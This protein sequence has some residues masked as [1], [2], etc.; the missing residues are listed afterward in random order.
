MNFA[1]RFSIAFY[2]SKQ[3]ISWSLRRKTSAET[4]V[5]LPYW[6]QQN[7]KK[8]KNNSS[9]FT[10]R[11]SLRTAPTE[12]LCD[13]GAIQC[14]QV[15]GFLCSTMFICEKNEEECQKNWYER[16]TWWNFIFRSSFWVP[17]MATVLLINFF[18]ISCESNFYHLFS[19]IV[20]FQ[21]Q[22]DLEQQT[23]Q[24]PLSQVKNRIWTLSSCTY[25][26]R[27]ICRENY[28]NCTTKATDIEKSDSTEGTSCLKW[29][30][31]NGGRKLFA[32]YQKDADKLNKV[33]YRYRNSINPKDSERE[34]NWHNT[35]NYFRN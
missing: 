31:Y 2:F 19:I 1:N 26:V 35:K 29:T 20:F 24:K 18:V 27:K 6:I 5:R 7:P 9:L 8:W 34:L 17:F 25:K 33:V 10:K 23:W 16:K 15:R 3:S 12:D 28:T 11:M 21:S 4:R 22:D 32:N 14:G 30:K 13:S